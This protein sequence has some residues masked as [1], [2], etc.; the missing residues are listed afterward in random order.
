M[1]LLQ[2]YEIFIKIIEKPKE[3]QK[4]IHCVGIIL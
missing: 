3:F 2:K 1:Y 4:N